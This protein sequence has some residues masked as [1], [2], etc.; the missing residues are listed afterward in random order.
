MDTNKE[1]HSFNTFYA[2]KYGIVGAILI[3][4]FIHWILVNKR[5]NRNFHDGRWWTYQTI[6]EIAAIFNY[7]SKDQVKRTLEYLS[8]ENVLVKGNYNKTKFDRTVWYAFVNEE[9]FLI[10]E[11]RQMEKAESPHLY[12]IL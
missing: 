11:N 4:N 12:Q 8:K 10:C 9:E 7:L 2:H 5:L 1:F 6:D 3:Q